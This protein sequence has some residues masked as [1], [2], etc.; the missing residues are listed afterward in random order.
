MD[1]TRASRVVGV[2]NVHSM[3]GT[4][5][6]A[7]CLVGRRIKL[8]LENQQ[9]IMSMAS[10]SSA[11]FVC[12]IVKLVAELEFRGWLVKLLRAISRMALSCV[13]RSAGEPV[14]L[15]AD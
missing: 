13:T 3:A 15:A 2:R 5:G 1:C 11:S 10:S 4:V 9:F 7:R 6:A 12:R 14:K 8:M